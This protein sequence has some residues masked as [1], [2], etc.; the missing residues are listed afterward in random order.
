MKAFI[1]I[2]VDEYETSIEHLKDTEIEAIV[3]C[4]YEYIASENV[5]FELNFTR[6]LEPVALN[7]PQDFMKKIDKQRIELL[8]YGFHK[9]LKIQMDSI[10]DSNFVCSCDDIW[11]NGTCGTLMCGCIDVCRNRCGTNYS[12][13]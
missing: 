3:T 7:I 9:N 11:C 1:R 6:Y 4:F 13:Y 12:N 8:P 2:F 10:S 5:S